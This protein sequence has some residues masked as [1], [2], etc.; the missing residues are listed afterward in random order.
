MNFTS[1]LFSKQW[2]YSTKFRNSSLKIKD[3]VLVKITIYYSLA[4]LAEILRYF[5]IVRQLQHR[6][7]RRYQIWLLIYRY[8]DSIFIAVLTLDILLHFYNTIFLSMSPSGRSI[9]EV[10]LL[11]FSHAVRSMDLTNN[12]NFCCHVYWP[13]IVRV[14][15]WVVRPTHTRLVTGSK[16]AWRKNPLV[17]A[18]IVSWKI[19]YSV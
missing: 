3:Y 4:I 10:A 6:R 15:Q 8:V 13:T 16:H 1:A 18:M 9:L 17:F 12:L 2:N 19:G 11:T 14:A 7:G 5:I